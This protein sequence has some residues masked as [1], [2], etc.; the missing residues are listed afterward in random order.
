MGRGRRRTISG[1]LTIGGDVSVSTLARVIACA[2]AADAG[3][4]A[5]VERMAGLGE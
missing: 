3:V 4:L 1:L 5:G 2:G